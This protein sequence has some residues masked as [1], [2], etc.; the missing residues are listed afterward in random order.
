MPDAR[1]NGHPALRL[2]GNAHFSFPGVEGESLLMR[3]D[4]GRD[5]LLRRLRL[6]QR[7]LWSPATSCPPWGFRPTMARSSVR[8]SLGR[9]N[10]AEE[11]DRVLTVLPPIVGGPALAHA[12]LTRLRV[13]PVP[14]RLL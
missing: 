8:F 3:L 2:P 13:R 5:R 14:F 6:H 10:T 1:L 11:I 7:Q 4:S 12:F 9:D